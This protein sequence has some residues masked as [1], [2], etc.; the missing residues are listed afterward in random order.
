MRTASRTNIFESE[1]MASLIKI[2][3][4]QE[5]EIHARYVFWINH[6]LGTEYF[7]Y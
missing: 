2:S 6:S 3:R 4:L 1:Q 5:S 7:F